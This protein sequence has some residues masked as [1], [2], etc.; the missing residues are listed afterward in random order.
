M[1]AAFAAAPQARDTGREI[2]PD[3]NGT[4]GRGDA[5]RAGGQGLLGG[6]KRFVQNR[7]ISPPISGTA[8]EHCLFPPIAFNGGFERGF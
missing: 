3:R 1:N 2:V 6:T 4:A 5:Y 8:W 7:T